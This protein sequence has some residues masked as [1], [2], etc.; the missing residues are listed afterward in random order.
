MSDCKKALTEV[1][2]DIDKAID[3]PAREGGE[4]G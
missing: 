3:I 1:D 4:E 2:G